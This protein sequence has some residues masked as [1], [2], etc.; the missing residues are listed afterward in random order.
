[1][2]NQKNLYFL[3]LLII[4][5]LSIVA[6]KDKRGADINISEDQIETYWKNGETLP[7][8][9]SEKYPLQKQSIKNDN[10]YNVLIDIAHQTY[11]TSMWALSPFLNELGYR[12][13][14]SQA[15]IHSVLEKNGVSRVRIPL[16]KG[17][18][19]LAWVP[20]FE[21][22]IILTEQSNPLFQPYT[23][24]EIKALKAFVNEGGGLAIQ[25]DAHTHLKSSNSSFEKLLK[26]FDVE[27]TSEK[28][29]IPHKLYATFKPGKNWEISQKGINGKPIE[30]RRKYGKGRLLIV[31]ALNTF[32]PIK[33]ASEPEREKQKENIRKRMAWLSEGKKPIGGEPCLPNQME[34]GGSI[35]PEKEQRIGNFMVLYAENQTQE[36]FDCMQNDLPLTQKLIQDWFPSKFN[37]IIYLVIAAGDG[38]GWGVN[39]YKP[40]EIG[41]IGSSRKYLIEAFSFEMGHISPGP[42]NEEGHNHG[43]N[44]FLYETHIQ[45]GWIQGKILAYFNHELQQKANCDANKIFE[46]DPSGK[47]VDISKFSL[48]YS[49]ESNERNIKTWYIFQKLDDRYGTTWYPRWL[50]VMN[51]RWKNKLEKHLT[52]EET[53]EDM[54]IAV[55]ED[56]FP[57]FY[58]LGT[59]LKTKRLE[60]IDFN[61]T[62]IKLK[63][64]PLTYSPAGKVCL[65]SIKD[66]KQPLIFP[67]SFK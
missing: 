21:Y 13:V 24:K 47:R 59:P 52:I 28:D 19:P 34:G 29:S 18:Y 23:E 50:W 64:A 37:E 57:F 38:G 9:I 6:C 66:Y 2:N 41:I 44:P 65:N 11:F 33:A 25:C 43:W 48:Q 53:I 61:G 5:L 30:I 55:G 3:L 17:I 27:I 8:N 4:S 63:A 45:A 42:A 46:I 14:S 62:T 15:T 26:I 10:G 56:L 60:Q 67:S 1:M 31:G 7:L 20:N 49:T 35:Y 58:E 51:T 39:S 32:Q 22:N 40:K 36:V 16:E 12:A 54:C